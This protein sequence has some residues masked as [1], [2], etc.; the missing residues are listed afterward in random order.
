MKRFLASFK[1][2]DDNDPANDSSI[3]H[4]IKN[5]YKQINN[6]WLQLH[7]RTFIGLV[8]FAFLFEVTVAVAFYISGNIEISLAKYALK[9][10]LFPLL[11]NSCFVGI[12]IW[13]MHLSHFSQKTKV[14]FISLL[15]VGV[16]FIFYIVHII[17]DSLYLI[18]FAPILLTVI[19]SNYMLTTITAFASI[20]A[21]VVSQLFITWDPDKT[22]PLSGSLTLTDFIISTIVLLGLYFISMVVVRF[23]KEKN[24]A[25][26][27]KEI[28]HQKVKEKLIIDELTD[29]YNRTALRKAFEDMLNNRSKASYIFVM[30]DLDNFKMVN[31][32]LGHLYGDQLLRQLGSILKK[33]CPNHATPFRYG[34]DEFCILLKNAT[35]DET[36]NICENI[37]C[38]LKK[39]PV[40]LSS[41]IQLTVSI[42][43]ARHEKEMSPTQL[44][45]NTDRALYHSKTSKNSI[46]IFDPQ[47]MENIKNTV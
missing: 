34:G 20:S 35:M 12:G 1:N 21:K 41:D 19:Y 8:L 16:C 40:N 25:S 10:V 42:G 43:I 33:N 46:C 4:E 17:F 7:Y 37:Q 5:E 27:K 31:D 24:E 45:Q 29:I 13:V 2:P 3:I 23:E 26:I 11:I 18:F 44:L 38:D 9:Y 36:L 28:A 32:F 14:Y 30:I 22:N 39:N 6:R 47:M 15:F